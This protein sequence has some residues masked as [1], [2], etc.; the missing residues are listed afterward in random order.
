MATQKFVVTGDQY[1]DIDRKMREIKRQLDQ[2]KGSPLSPVQVE[3]ALQQIVEGNF[4][5]FLRITNQLNIQ[6]PALPRPTLQQLRER[7]SF[8]QSIERD[9]SPISAVTLCLGTV[10]RIGETA[11]INGTEYELRL[12]PHFDIVLGFQHAVWLEAYQD[13][14]PQLM[15]L[16]GKVYIDFSGLVVLGESG[17]HDVP[18]FAQSGKRW[19]LFLPCVDFYFD[20]D[21]R[22]AVASK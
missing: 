14:F 4:G 6:I 16:L 22:V 2:D 8:T 13:E 1:R 19:K 11:P 5:D 10:F 9:T 18:Y 15:A 21:G 20:L 3:F 7:W 17:G 12:T